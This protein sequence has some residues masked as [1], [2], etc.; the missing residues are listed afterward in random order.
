MTS[1]TLAAVVVVMP[2]FNEEA[3]FEFIAEIDEHLGDRV[4]SLRFVVVDDASVEPVLAAQLPAAL[5]GRVHVVRNATNVGHGPSALRAYR[6]GIV[7]APD[8]VLHVDGDGQFVGWEFADL[9]EQALVHG[10]AIGVRRS[11]TD[12]WFRRVISYVARILV[13][14]SA[15]LPDVNSPLRA[16]RVAELQRLLAAVPEASLVPHLQF[17]MLHPA[18]GI[19]PVAVGVTSIC[20]RGHS[21]VGSTWSD[22]GSRQ[23]LPSRRLLG[24]AL[25]AF[26]EILRVRGGHRLATRPAPV[27]WQVDRA[28]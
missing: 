24:F 9:L 26:V 20:R 3:I 25:R 23:V 7:L 22:S 14:A 11:R 4:A 28:R 13:A 6:E 8:I 12:P 18:L 16:Y 21:E 17:T 5:A 15:E 27:T 19:R 1:R 2:A 10:A